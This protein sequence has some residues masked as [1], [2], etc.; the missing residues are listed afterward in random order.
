MKH[1]LGAAATAAV[2]FGG[3]LSVTL[4]PARAYQIDCAI[5]LCLSGGWPASEPCAAAKAEFIRRITPWPIE[6]PLQIWRCPMH[7]AYPGNAARAPEQR[8]YDVA[9][10]RGAHP[11]PSPSVFEVA[12]A[13]A[14]KGALSPDALISAV[15]K[16]GAVGGALLQQVADY[17]SENGVADI[18]ISDRA[19]DF[20]RSIRVYSVE[21]MRQRAVDRDNNYCRRLSRV[22]IGRY[23]QQGEFY[24]RNADP[25][26]LPDAYVGDEGWGE[27]CPRISG[28]S[29]F[30]DWSD[31]QGNYGY[32]QVNY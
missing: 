30:V 3:G 12:R 20:V 2:V 22:R 16:D 26:A 14:R 27:D 8:L 23:G 24:W 29:V 9:F 32:E 11:L 15:L 18:D 17:T 25:S 21:Y 13:G 5:L 10:D 19:F 28:R 4:Q 6:P 1:F 7:A 31:H